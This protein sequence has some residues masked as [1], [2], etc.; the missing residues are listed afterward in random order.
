MSPVRR[1][2]QAV[3]RLFHCNIEFQMIIEHL[4]L[5][6]AKC[7]SRI[8]VFIQVV[9]QVYSI[10][11]AKAMVIIVHILRR[12]YLWTNS[13]VLRDGKKFQQNN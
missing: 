11:H 7:V 8:F 4:Q 1:E 9:I 12:I 6:E 3:I 10:E 13:N 2:N 5:I